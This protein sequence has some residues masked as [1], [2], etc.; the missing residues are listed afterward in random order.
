MD[1]TLGSAAP[2]RLLFGLFGN[3]V[4]NTVE[5]FRALCVGDQ[6][7]KESGKPLAFKGSAFH[8]IIS[9]FM[10][11]GGDFTNGDGTGGE[12]IYGR[13]FNVCLHLLPARLA[14]TSGLLCTEVLRPRDLFVT[15]AVV[16]AARCF[17]P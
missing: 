4:P 7:G 17:G 10:A 12:S 6:I 5:N 9:G 11:Q 14:S 2:E 8:R 13:T 16:H 15:L 3:V 1:V